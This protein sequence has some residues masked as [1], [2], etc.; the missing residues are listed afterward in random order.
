MAVLTDFQNF[1]AVF[2]F[3]EKMHKKISPLGGVS[4]PRPAVPLPEARGCVLSAW[5]TFIS[6]TTGLRA[7]ED[8]V[9]GVLLTLVGHTLTS[10][11]SWALLPIPHLFKLLTTA[12]ATRF[13][14]QVYRLSA[15]RLALGGG[16]SSLSGFIIAQVL[17]FVKHFFYFLWD[18]FQSQRWPPLAS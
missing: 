12:Y 13:R 1:L 18:F 14:L 15:T 10:S 8:F 3:D 11:V 2:I 6:R 17:R 5:F 9:R 7:V 4:L 16:L